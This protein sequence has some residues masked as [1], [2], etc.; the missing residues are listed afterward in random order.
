MYDASD[1]T[2]VGLGSDKESGICS[3]AL[4]TRSIDA[5]QVVVDMSKWK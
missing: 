5:G 3:M 1:G 4:P 2:K